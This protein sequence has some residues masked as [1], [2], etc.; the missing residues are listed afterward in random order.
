MNNWN[1][2]DKRVIAYDAIYGSDIFNQLPP[3]KVEKV[4]NYY[5]NIYNDFNN[6]HNLQ[7]RKENNKYINKKQFKKNPSSPNFK[8]TYNQSYIYNNNM[9]LEK[10]NKENEKIQIN[11]ISQ[12]EINNCRKRNIDSLK[13]NIF[14][15][16]I[17]EKQNKK[18]NSNKSINNIWNTNLDW[19]NAK[20]ELVFYNKNNNYN[21][22]KIE[23]L[24]KEKI[25]NFYKNKN[26][27]NHQFKI[28]DSKNIDMIQIKKDLENEGIHLFNMEYKSNFLNG[29][30]DQ[31]VTFKIRENSPNEFRK[32]LE[33]YIN[34]EELN[35][36]NIHNYKVDINPKKYYQGNQKNCK[37]KKES[38]IKE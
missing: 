14:N 4:Y 37:Y 3:K 28:N 1:L 6:Y 16:K 25:K 12:K 24:K 11:N 22:N 30:K 8:T 31:S 2:K 33:N 34:N 23:D 5:D 15:D 38:K 35:L 7:Q 10:N 20:S 36:L 17:K 32:K 13:S 19:R 9:N 18:F 29:H 27:M 26:I 21:K